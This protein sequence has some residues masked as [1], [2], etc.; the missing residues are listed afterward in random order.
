MKC[1]DVG[2]DSVRIVMNAA[3]RRDN[4]SSNCGMRDSMRTIGSEEEQQDRFPEYPH[5]TGLILSRIQTGIIQMTQ[6][7]ETLALR[8]AGSLLFACRFFNT[9]DAHFT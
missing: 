8:I 6:A 9:A 7:T 1:V 4:A 3:S 2:A 5:A